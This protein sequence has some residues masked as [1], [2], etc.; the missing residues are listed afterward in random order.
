MEV[1]CT[2]GHTR[3]LESDIIQTAVWSQQGDKRPMTLLALRTPEY[4]SRD[5][6]EDDGLHKQEVI[7][8]P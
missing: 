1:R 2:N 7:L 3:F 8:C 6:E 4:F 5:I